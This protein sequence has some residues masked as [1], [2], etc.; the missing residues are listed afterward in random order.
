M[1]IYEYR[2]R[3]CRAEFEQMTTMAKAD[4]I[5]CKQCGSKKTERL[6]SVFGVGAAKPDMPC[7]TDACP[8]AKGCASGHCPHL[9]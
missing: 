5:A 7:A 6:L 8:S 1:P 4:D 3:E 9:Q 2:C